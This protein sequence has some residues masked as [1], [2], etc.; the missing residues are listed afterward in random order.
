M[1]KKLKRFFAVLLSAVLLLSMCALAQAK[2]GPYEEAF[3]G[4]YPAFLTFMQMDEKGEAVVVV[5]EETPWG[6]AV[7]FPLWVNNK[8]AAQEGAVYDRKTNTLTL[9]D[10]NHPDYQLTAN[11]MGDD[12]TVRVNGACAL[13]EIAVWGD[14]WGGSLHITGEGS[15]TVNAG[16]VFD[17][18]LIFYPEGVET[19]RFAV[20]ASVRLELYGKETALEVY[21]YEG[22]FDASVGGA[23]LVLDKKNAVR[24]QYVWLFG[25]S[26]PMEENLR[27]AKNKADPDGV[28]SL[29]EWENDKGEKHV[30]VERFVHVEKYDLYL[31]DEAWIEETAGEGAGEV[32][33]D[34]LEEAAAAGFTPVKQKNGDDTWLEVRS[35]GNRGPE[36]VY[37]SADGAR[38]VVGF[39]KND[40]GEYGE[41]AMTMEPIEEIPG[42]YIFTY[43]PGVD[44]ES[45]TEVTET[46]TYDDAFDYAY[47]EKELKTDSLPGE[48]DFLPGDV[49]GDGEVTASDARLAL[50]AAVGLDDSAEGY[51]FS[52]PTNRCYRAA[53]VDGEAGISAS[54]ARLILRAA[55]GLE[56]LK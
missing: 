1:K 53:D 40:K 29:L 19:L 23:P 2:T 31:V 44:P 47:P 51:D 13:D 55:V 50:R 33:F 11:M 35:L 28:Y 9:T 38:Y 39:T 22:A 18:G 32:R 52:E 14:G 7:T 12:F 3:D 45:L 20:D 17:S 41:F 8:A 46:V 30:T 10:F 37:E 24:E 36:N 21:G 4:W 5:S 48:D 25:Y 15:L 49:D 54:D 6:E 34:T 27:L 43:A 56:T 26:G 16:R 42:A